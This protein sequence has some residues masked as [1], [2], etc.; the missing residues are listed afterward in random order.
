MKK[1]L[2]L[3]TILFGSLSAQAGLFGGNDCGCEVE[4][5]CGE[6]PA[7]CYDCA[8]PKAETIVKLAPCAKKNKPYNYYTYEK[9][10]EKTFAGDSYNWNTPAN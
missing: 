6:E 3:A 8:E 1:S 5:V 2:L 10:A 7:V 9:A 4:P